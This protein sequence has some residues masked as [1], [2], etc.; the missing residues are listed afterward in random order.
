MLVIL[1]AILFTKKETNQQTNEEVKV[2]L[3][4]T[5]IYCSSMWELLR[6]S[7][8]NEGLNSF[9]VFIDLIM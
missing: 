4:H 6:I 2:M 8:F 7:N 9:V 5:T 1:H 3:V